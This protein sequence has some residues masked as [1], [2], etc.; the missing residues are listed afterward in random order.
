M[1][2]AEQ[3]VLGGLHGRDLFTDPLHQAEAVAVVYHR[4]RVVA[5]PG[6]VGLDCRA[7]FVEL[8]QDEVA[9]LLQRLRLLR[10]VADRVVEMVQRR[11]QLRG[12]AV[13]GLEVGGAAGQEIAALTGLGALHQAENMGQLCADV[14]R[15]EH[16]AVIVFT[17]GAQPERRRHDQRCQHGRGEQAAVQQSQRS[18]PKLRLN[19]MLRLA[20]DGSFIQ[21]A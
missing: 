9:Q 21:S 18:L 19:Q 5:V 13:V 6:F 20:V 2:S 12:G 7:Q 14:E 4:Q 11:R 16:P 3:A 15:V 10:I 8:G 17:A 1:T